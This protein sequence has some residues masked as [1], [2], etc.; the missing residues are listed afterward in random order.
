M[1]TNLRSMIYTSLKYLECSETK[2]G[3]VHIGTHFLHDTTLGGILVLFVF[4]HYGLVYTYLC[5]E[6]WINI[7][8]E[9]V[10]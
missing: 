8:N 7:I 9:F 2:N 1:T 6:H 3:L 4:I 5:L 10:F